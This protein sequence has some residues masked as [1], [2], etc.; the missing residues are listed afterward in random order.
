MRRTSQVFFRVSKVSFRLEKSFYRLCAIRSDKAFRRFSP[1]SRSYPLSR[2][3]AFAVFFRCF[4]IFLYDFFRQSDFTHRGKYFAAG[5]SRVGRRKAYDLQS[6]VY[7]RAVFAFCNA[8]RLSHVFGT[9]YERQR[10]YYFQSVGLQL[11]SHF[12][13]GARHGARHFD[14]VLFRKR[15][16]FAARHD[17]LQSSAPYDFIVEPRRRPRLSCGKAAQH[18]DAR[19]RGCVRHES[20]RSRHHRYGQRRKNANHLCRRVGFEIRAQR[21]R[22]HAA[23]DDGCPRAFF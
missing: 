20:F 8:R 10:N 14:C 18:G 12:D 16:S 21:G 4:F 15:L 9:L 7:R 2:A 19:Y 17:P 6:S 11:R 13:S 5:R 23:Y 22:A 3:R 1:S